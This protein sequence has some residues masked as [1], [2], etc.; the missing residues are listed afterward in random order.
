MV[1]AKVAPIGKTC[2]QRERG[3]AAQG[4]LEAGFAIWALLQ[5]TQRVTTTTHRL[6]PSHST[7][8]T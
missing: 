8:T 4:N 6:D 3:D 5:T 2:P 7:Y 1:P